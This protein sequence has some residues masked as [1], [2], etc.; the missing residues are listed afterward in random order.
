MFLI[1]ILRGTVTKV[2]GDKTLIAS[3]VS[4]PERGDPVPNAAPEIGETAGSELL[5]HMPENVHV[6][7]F[8]FDHVVE[9]G[10]GE[11]A[12]VDNRIKTFLAVLSDEGVG[13]RLG[14]GLRHELLV[15][16]EE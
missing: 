4:A 14:V 3:S 10:A 15:F 5:L 7:V 13:G 12:L 6:E 11:F 16:K 1:N 8:L 9:R 2:F